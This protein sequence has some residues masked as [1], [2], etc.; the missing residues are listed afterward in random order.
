MRAATFKPDRRHKNESLRKFTGNIL[1][2]SMWHDRVV[3]H[4][5][6]TNRAWRNIL[7]TMRIWHVPITKDWLLTQSHAGSTG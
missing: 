3:D 4:L 7:D 2:Y 1:Y 6:R 5:C